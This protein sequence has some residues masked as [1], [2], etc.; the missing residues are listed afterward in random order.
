[1]LEKLYSVPEAAEALRISQWTVWAWLKSGKL[2]GVKIGDR[3]VIRES[4]L[5]RLIVDDGRMSRTKAE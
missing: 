4:E 2:R 3:R 5:Q 1:M